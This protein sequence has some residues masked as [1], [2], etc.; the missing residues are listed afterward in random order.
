MLIIFRL[1]SSFQRQLMLFARRLYTHRLS[2]QS[3]ACIWNYTLDCTCFPLQACWI[4]RLIG[5]NILIA[6]I[7]SLYLRFWGEL[8][9]GGGVC[10]LIL[11]IPH[12]MCMTAPEWLRA[13]QV[14]PGRW[15]FAAFFIHFILTRWLFIPNM[16][17]KNVKTFVTLCE[18][19]NK[20][21]FTVLTL[22]VII[23]MVTYGCC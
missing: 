14:L 7:H 6:C 20:N 15:T 22:Q 16:S 4:Q 2:R 19:E 1:I 9:A 23:H 12:F 3:A 8:W 10:L 21:I 17:K 11:P 5:E 13:F 18:K